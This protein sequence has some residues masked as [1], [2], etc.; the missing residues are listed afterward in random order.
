MRWKRK[1]REAAEEVFA[2]ARDRV[3]RCGGVGGL[4]EKE[5]ERR[6]K[7]WGWGWDEGGMDKRGDEK[8][9]DEEGGRS[10][11]DD[12]EGV[13]GREEGAE[14][15]NGDDE[16]CGVNDDDDDDEERGYTMDM[17]FKSLGIDLRIIGFDGALQRWVD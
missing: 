16:G 4:R 1:S 9:E 17:M 12:V 10:A 6:G 15:R 7:G 11:R 3:N 2:V 8:E 14:G 5:K 13:D